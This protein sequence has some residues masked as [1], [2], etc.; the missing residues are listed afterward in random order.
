MFDP[1]SAIN[2]SARI[3]MIVIINITELIVSCFLQISL[4][5]I[6]I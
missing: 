2:K 4:V 6:R 5:L 3:K 1:I